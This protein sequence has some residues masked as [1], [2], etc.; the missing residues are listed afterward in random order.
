MKDNKKILQITL[1]KRKIP[2]TKFG[3]WLYWKVWFQIW[4]IWRPHFIAWFFGGLSDFMYWIAPKNIKEEWDKEFENIEINLIN[5]TANK[6]LEKE[7]E[8]SLN[9]Y[10]L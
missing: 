2:K 9:N 3:K 10:N 7:I 8:E 5:E 6:E 1:S 4:S